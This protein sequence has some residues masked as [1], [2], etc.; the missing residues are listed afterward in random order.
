MAFLLY[1]GIGLLILVILIATGIVAYCLGKRKRSDGDDFRYA[2]MAERVQ[3]RS[4]EIQ[5]KAQVQQ[6]KLQQQQQQAVSQHSAEATSTAFHVPYSVLD[7]ATNS[8]SDECRIGT[9]GSCIV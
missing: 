5:F 3:P 7:I 4:S 6:Q 1:A 9:G 2:E 8:F